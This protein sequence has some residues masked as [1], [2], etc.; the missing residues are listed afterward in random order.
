MARE[1]YIGLIS[2][3]SMDGIDCGLLACDGDQFELLQTHSHPLPDPVRT[4]IARISHSG[5]D[6]IERLGILDR[7]LGHLFA[8]GALSLLDAAGLKPSAIT[9]IGSHGQTI[10]HRPA[11]RGHSPDTAFTLQIADP[12]TIAEQTG[13]TTIADFRRRDMAAGGEGAPLAP[14]FHAAAFGREG[15][16]RVVANIGG[17]GNVSL[18]DGASLLAGYDTGPGNTLMDLW[19]ERHRGQTYDADG[20]WAAT[21]A[22]N[23][24]L[25]AALLAHPYLALSHPKSTGKEEFNLVW[26]DS[27]LSARSNLAAADVQATLSQFTAETLVAAVETAGHSPDTWFICGGGAHNCD[28][29]RRIADRVNRGVDVLSTQA[30]GLGP[31][32]VE[33][34]A[35]GWLA[36]RTLE[37]LPG[38]AP[39]VT[40]AGGDRVLG[41]IYPAARKT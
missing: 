3:T 25:L 27:V 18:L 6:E 11:S 8:A 19:I 40:G 32:W 33:A 38:N 14:A 4:D 35:F 23:P 10:R 28:L 37:G 13:I 24:D 16:S 22:L 5:D 36:R 12:N 2:G 1:L 7:Q 17:I 9:A 39:A 34:A 30:L 41:G 26:L 29:M 31:D 15:E 20:A 21:G